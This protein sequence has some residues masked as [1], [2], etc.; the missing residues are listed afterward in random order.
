MHAKRMRSTRAITRSH[1]TLIGVVIIIILLVVALSAYYVSTL[2][3][4]TTSSTL[5]TTSSTG[6]AT[7]LSPIRSYVYIA[8]GGGYEFQN[9]APAQITVVLGVNNTVTWVNDDV[10][11]HTVTSR[12]G[13]FNS[14]LINPNTNW[15]YTF[16]TAGVY[17][18]Y[19]QVHLVM[20]G[21][22]TVLASTATG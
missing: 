9:Y 10:I 13:I 12:T 2:G 6:T 11:A 17:P 19:C 5:P 22:V 20:N 21:S 14:G 15:T 3:K 4:S 1:V 8:N 16:T 18:Y 7:G